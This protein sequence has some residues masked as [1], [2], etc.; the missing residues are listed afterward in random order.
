MRFQRLEL[1]KYGR[2]SGLAIEFPKSERD[3]HVIVGL[4]EAGKS[5]LRSA[6]LDLLYG[7]DSR[8][9]YDFLYAGSD[10][11]LGA[12]INNKTGSLEF[13][14][15]KGKKNTLRSPA[16]AVLPDSALSQFLSATDRKFFDQMFGLDHDRLVE[17]SNSILRAENDVGQVLFQSAAGIASLG[18][19]RDDLFAE[20]EK[21][22]AP[23]KAAD[24]A[25]YAAADKF[26]K[27]TSALREATVRTKMW[28]EANNKFEGLNEALSRE[29]YRHQELERTRIR[30]ERVRRLA[31]YLQNLRECEKKLEDL[32]DVP[33]LPSDAASIFSA[34]ERQLA[35]DKELLDVRVRDVKKV[36]EDLAEV[37]VDDKL[38]QTK[39]DIIK[40]DELRLQYGAY[41]RDIELRENEVANL[42]Q[43]VGNACLELGWRT[44]SE[45]GLIERIPT[46]LVRRELGELAKQF[47]GLAQ[48]KRSAKQAEDSKVSEIEALTAQLADIPTGEVKPSLGAAIKSART[49]GDPDAALQSKQAAISKAKSTL[50]ISLQALGQWSKPLPALAAM[51]PPSQQKIGLLIQERQTL[52]AERKTDFQRLEDQKTVVNRLTLEIAQFKRQHNPTTQDAVQ[53]ARSDRDATWKSIKEGEMDIRQGADQFEKKISHADALADNRLDDVEEATELQSK[54]NELERQNQLQS[55]LEGQYSKVNADL[56]RF[57]GQWTDLATGAGLAGIPLSDIADWLQKREKVLAAAE[58]YQEAQD[59]LNLLSRT[60]EE[61]TANLLTAIREAG[62]AGE[63][64]DNLSTL[65]IQAENFIKGVASAEVRR[66]TL[67][68]QLKSAQIQ[69]R[70]LK[71]ATLD[72][73]ADMKKWTGAWLEALEKAGLPKDDTIGSVE[74]S[75]EL[76]G[77]IEEKLEK[78]RQI[79][80]ERINAMKTDLMRFSAEADRLADL[81]DSELKGKPAAQTATELRKRLEKTQEA[82]SEMDRLKKALDA[83]KGKVAATEESILKATASLRPLMD[84][85]R[86]ES[87]DLLLEAITRSD[88]KAVLNAEITKAQT[89]LLTGGDG[90]TRDAIEAEIGGTDLSQLP[91]EIERIN[92]E[93]ADVVQNLAALSSDRATAQTALSAIGGSDAAAQAEAQRQEALSQMS[94]VS[95]RYCKVHVAARLLNFAIDKYRQ[96]KQGPLLT[97]TS[98]LFSKLTLGSFQ[99]LVIDFEQEPMVLEGLRPDGKRVS[100]SG[101]SN[102]A[103]DQLYMALRLAALELHIEQAMPLPFI[104]DDLFI[105]FDDNRSKAGFEALVSL[106]EKTQI[107][108][109]SHHDHLVPVVQEVFGRQVNIIRL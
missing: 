69:I 12:L 11:R 4:N 6:I 40:L 57:D 87:N 74:G 48:A 88:R 21:L 66:Q 49:I 31:P 20:S 86:V 54:I 98:A 28:V 46:L 55:V 27:A 45:E 17:G 76:I 90:L 109:L 79:R 80:A 63:D 43:E 104:A 53:E 71:Q 19:V 105:N 42:W 59:A 84:R 89:S 106:S 37:N 65:C 24:R 77:R 97:R 10:L 108:F 9:P 5:T 50:D 101:L 41:G 51:Q 34:A 36:K 68:D 73:D 47:S 92:T 56:E 81:I 61:S 14:R 18:Q 83:A 91:A 29:N 44:D 64:K 22:W 33:N 78:M 85:A 102:G 82:Q 15:V 39:A 7:I 94:D 107:I 99:K 16:D 93:I 32:G 13:H 8:S 3:F 100:I 60:I 38:L 95:E 96:E 25:Y 26:E 70:N 75:L 72:A 52:V 62:L 2:F 58:G 1:L 30:L 23:R 103:R 67:T 35:I